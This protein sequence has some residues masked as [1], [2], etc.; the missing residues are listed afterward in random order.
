MCFDSYHLV[1][2]N[3]GEVVLSTETHRH[4]ENRPDCYWIHQ[5]LLE[6]YTASKRIAGMVLQTHQF[7]ITS[8]HTRRRYYKNH[9][10]LSKFVNV[11]ICCTETVEEKLT[12]YW[13]NPATLGRSQCLNPPRTATHQR[14]NCHLLCGL[15]ESKQSATPSQM[16]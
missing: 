3:Q 7:C 2:R 14:N 10:A 16:H 6:C 1:R 5:G 9:D 4:T 15:R 13:I 8:K 11:S 12:C